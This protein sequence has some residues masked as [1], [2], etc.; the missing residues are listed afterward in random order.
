MQ[1]TQDY[2]DVTASFR[3]RLCILTVYANAKMLHLKFQQEY[4]S[5][6]DVILKSSSDE[7]Y[8]GLTSECSHMEVFNQLKDLYN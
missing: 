3:S 8:T 6:D 4:I 5:D 7:V 2:V 1:Q